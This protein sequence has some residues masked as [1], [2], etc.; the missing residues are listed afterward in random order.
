M[1]FNSTN[2]TS[3]NS[4]EVVTI[5]EVIAE[6]LSNLTDSMANNTL[7]NNGTIESNTTSTTETLTMELDPMDF[8]AALIYI[9]LNVIMAIIPLAIFYGVFYSD[10]K[11]YYGRNGMFKASEY[12]LWIGNLIIY[13]IPAIFGG[14]TWLWNAY[15]V[16]GY[17]AWTQYIVVWGGLGIQ[18][19]NFIL[20]IAGAATFKNQPKL[21]APHK[22]PKVESHSYDSDDDSDDDDG[23]TST[24]AWINMGVWMAITGGVYTG[25]WL[26]N[27]N[28]LS[29]YVIEEIIHK[30]PAK[31]RF[32]GEISDSDSEMASDTEVDEPE[33]L[34]DGS[35]E[36]IIM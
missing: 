14:F 32:N 4:T 10:V 9:G 25:Y 27:D 35:T 2:S 18:G 6:V 28:F 36:A 16:A 13:G 33:F 8:P 24:D 30:I 23:V 26:L 11:T 19:L 34:D 7:T 20:M 29:Y 31:N 15:I 12:F 3:T 22:K 5:N 21:Y 1:A 17:V